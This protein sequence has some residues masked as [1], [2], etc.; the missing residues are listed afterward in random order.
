MFLKYIKLQNEYYI[1]KIKTYN[2]EGISITQS[3]K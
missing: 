3:K 1:C 2:Y